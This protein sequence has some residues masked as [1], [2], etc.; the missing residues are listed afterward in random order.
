VQVL[1][2]QQALSFLVVGAFWGC[3]NPLL[4]RASQG[5]DK[6]QGGWLAVSPRKLALET[7]CYQNKKKLLRT[8]ALDLHLLHSIPPNYLNFYL[9]N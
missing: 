6:V 4:K 1:T 3:T 9:H 8:L 7:T 2:A 5:I